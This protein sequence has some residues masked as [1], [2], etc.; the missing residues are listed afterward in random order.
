[1]IVRNG[2]ENACK[3]QGFYNERDSTRVLDHP[4]HTLLKCAERGFHAVIEVTTVEVSTVV[5]TRK[6]I[7]RESCAAQPSRLITTPNIIQRNQNHQSHQWSSRKI[8]ARNDLRSLSLLRR[9]SILRLTLRNTQQH[10]YAVAR[11]CAQTVAC[12]LVL[13]ARTH[14]KRRQREWNIRASTF[15]LL[16]RVGGGKGCRI[17]I[18]LLTV[19]WGPVAESSQRAAWP[20]ERH[21]LE[22]WVD[23]KAKRGEE[24][25][26]KDEQRIGGLEDGGKQ[27][28]REGCRRDRMDLSCALRQ[29]EAALSCAD[30]YHH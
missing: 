29:R 2:L 14:R 16:Q 19:L 1:M 12:G 24:E 7:S 27:S 21:S 8:L 6:L 23:A 9:P 25:S 26:E 3:Y 15:V 30:L 28:V 22:V 10:V 17:P 18:D 13:R 4:H 5:L 20:R 11:I